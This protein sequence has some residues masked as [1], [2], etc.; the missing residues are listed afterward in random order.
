MDTEK[1]LRAYTDIRNTSEVA[2]ATLETVNADNCLKNDRLEWVI[3]GVIEQIKTI[4]IAARAI[5]AIDEAMSAK[6]DCTA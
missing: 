3:I 6:E 4:Q 1:M 2:I 5:D